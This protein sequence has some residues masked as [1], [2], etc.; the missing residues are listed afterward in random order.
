MFTS[1]WQHK[2]A[3]NL[4]YIEYISVEDGTEVEFTGS[5][6]PFTGNRHI[7]ESNVLEIRLETDLSVGARGARWSFQACKHP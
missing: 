1:T 6:L 3:V 4:R 7:S 5:K 2:S